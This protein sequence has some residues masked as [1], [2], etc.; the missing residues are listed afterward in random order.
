MKSRGRY[1]SDKIVHDL[2]VSLFDEV[3]ILRQS[4]L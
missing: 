1:K 4:H 2:A 3:G